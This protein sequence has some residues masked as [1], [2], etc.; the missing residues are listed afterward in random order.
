MIKRYQKRAG[1]KNTISHRVGEGISNPYN[2]Q[3]IQIQIPNIFY[4][5]WSLGQLQDVSQVPQTQHVAN[6]THVSFSIPSPP[7][8]SEFTQSSNP[9][10]SQKTCNHSQFCPLPPFTS[11][12]SP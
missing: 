1:Q 5:S 3:Q 2:Q 12:L 10:A 7:S 9:P 6:F 11:N 8:L 4:T